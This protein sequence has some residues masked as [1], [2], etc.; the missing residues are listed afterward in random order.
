MLV[1]VRRLRRECPEWVEWIINPK[2]IKK[3][4]LCRAGDFLLCW[5]DIRVFLSVL[6]LILNKGLKGVEKYKK[7]VIFYKTD[8][9]NAYF[10]LH[11]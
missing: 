10:L 1:V 6:F 8:V 3:N 2:K 11:K 4:P 9:D 5:A 7:N